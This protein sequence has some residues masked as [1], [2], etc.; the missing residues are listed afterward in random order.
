MTALLKSGD[1]SPIREDVSAN[2]DSSDW[3][4]R[5]IRLQSYARWRQ[6][7]FIRRRLLSEGIG[8][9]PDLSSWPEILVLL[10]KDG[11]GTLAS[12][13]KILSSFKKMSG[14]KDAPDDQFDTDSRTPNAGILR[15]DPEGA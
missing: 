3:K 13:K 7:Y 12:L 10:E 15:D 9:L 11:E 6:A 2:N 4:K 8:G 14:E 5:E 1:S